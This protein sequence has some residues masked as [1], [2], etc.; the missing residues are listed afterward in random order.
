MGSWVRPA[1]IDIRNL[2]IDKGVAARRRKTS[3]E[4]CRVSKGSAP[5]MSPAE[6]SKIEQYIPEPNVHVC[7]VVRVH[8][9]QTLLK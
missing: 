9:S 3:A 2:E 1:G 5:F 8:E 6:T 7:N 4:R